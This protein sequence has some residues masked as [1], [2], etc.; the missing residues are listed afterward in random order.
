MDQYFPHDKT[1]NIADVFTGG[2][3][4]FPINERLEPY[5]L[6]LSNGVIDHPQLVSFA[7]RPVPTGNVVM[8][9]HSGCPLEIYDR[10]FRLTGAFKYFV[11]GVHTLDELTYLRAQGRIDNLIIT[12]K[13]G[14][15]PRIFNRSAFSIMNRV[16]EIEDLVEPE[17]MGALQEI[18]TTSNIETRISKLCEFLLDLLSRSNF[19][20][21][22]NHLEVLDIIHRNFGNVSLNEICENLNVT[23]RTLQRSFQV[24]VGISPKEYIR[25]VRFNCVFQY[26]LEDRL[27]DWQDIIHRFGYYDQ[28]HFIHDFKSVTG[29]TPLKFIDFRQHGAI[30]LDRFQ[31]V[32]KVTDLMR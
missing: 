17:M 15:F 3:K 7:A 12:F 9:L 31:V 1:R 16:I 25:I 11:T 4:I 29:F 24:N 22:K 30:Y 23:L 19:N 5:L 27:G 28:S 13:P 2:T 10:D 20:T 14:G 21:R 18:T 32:H 6:S 26:L 8:F